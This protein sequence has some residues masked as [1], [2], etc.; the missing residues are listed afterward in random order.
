MEKNVICIKWGTK[1]GA[2]Y[3]NRLYKMVEK[4][5]SIPHRFVCFTDNAEGLVEGI[6]VRD[7][8][9][10]N[11]NT[12]IGDTGWR[13]LSLF[14]EK[15]ADLKGT[16]LFLDLDIVI[17]QDL[18]PFFEAEG[19]FLIV[20]DWD[21]PKDIIGNSSVFR[22]K[23]GR[24]DFIIDEFIRNRQDIVSKYRNEQAYLSYAMYDAGIL[25]YWPL[26]WCVSFKRHC[27]QPWPLCYLKEPIDPVESKII[28]FHG[29]P[30]PEEAYN[31]YVS[32]LGFRYI[33]PT[34]WLEKYWQ[35]C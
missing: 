2:D 19:D 29:K 31:G 12:A 13:K 11:D 28:V 1:F 25:Q 7:L 10:Y 6:E 21:F 24:H 27:L 5:L 8:P 22:F 4:N 3:V 14:N 26:D 18:A 20:K 15:L 32:K 23:I 16:A 35:V 34:R 9:E 30:N 33:K 17:R